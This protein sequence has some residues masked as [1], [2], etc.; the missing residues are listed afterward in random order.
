M[1]YIVFKNKKTYV[2]YFKNYFNTVSTNTLNGTYILENK[3]TIKTEILKRK[4]NDF[5]MFTPVYNKIRKHVL[6]ISNRK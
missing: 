1:M 5:I 2:Y 3:R 6:I 4:N